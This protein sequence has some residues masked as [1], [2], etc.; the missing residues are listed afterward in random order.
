[1]CEIQR[2]T[3][4]VGRNNL[5]LEDAGVSLYVPELSKQHTHATTDVHNVQVDVGRMNAESTTVA[6]F[7]GS[8]QGHVRDASIRCLYRYCIGFAEIRAGS[9]TRA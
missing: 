7:D 8:D 6:V 4:H 9:H 2:N 5:H 3:L 1:M